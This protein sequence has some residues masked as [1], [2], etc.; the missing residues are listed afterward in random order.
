MAGEAL[1]AVPATLSAP[2]SSGIESGGLAMSS[3]APVASNIDSPLADFPGFA[4]L[5]GDM[6]SPSSLD[7]Q[8]SGLNPLTGPG[9][10]DLQVSSGVNTQVEQTVNVLSP[11]ETSLLVSLFSQPVTQEMEPGVQ[12][13]QEI[14]YADGL[15]AKRVEELANEVGV[16]LSKETAQLVGKLDT[17]VTESVREVLDSVTQVVGGVLDQELLLGELAGK[18]GGE[19]G[20]EGLVQAREVPVASS[21]ESL[22]PPDLEAEEAEARDEASEPSREATEASEGAVSLETNGQAKA[23]E[24][25]EEEAEDEQGEMSEEDYQAEEEEDEEQLPMVSPRVSGPEDDARLALIGNLAQQHIIGSDAADIFVD[26]AAKSPMV[27]QLKL[28]EDGGVLAIAEALKFT[29]TPNQVAFNGRRAAEKYS[30][31]ILATEGEQAPAEA[32]EAVGGL[33]R[34]SFSLAV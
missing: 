7:Q 34:N 4:V 15:V 29:S 3:V 12:L 30:A 24:S 2:V 1:S 13:A 20:E 18:E 17:P 5:S 33:R 28:N 27:Y 11:T 10:T 21:V 14:D 6:G 25:V 16:Q 31:V 22:Q 32:I 19:S 8:T 23:E 9:W 26:N